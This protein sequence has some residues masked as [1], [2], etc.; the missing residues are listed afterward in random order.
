MC[1]R[2]LA[3]PQVAIEF[4]GYA[5]RS[6]GRSPEFIVKSG[7]EA[8]RAPAHQT[9]KPTSVNY[10]LGKATPVPLQFCTFHFSIFSLHLFIRTLV[11]NLISSV[12]RRLARRSCF[13]TPV[14][15]EPLIGITPDVTL[16]GGGHRLREPQNVF[17]L[18]AGPL[19][20]QGFSHLKNQ[21]LPLVIPWRKGRKYDR[22]RPQ[23]QLSDDERGRC[24]S[25]KEIHK[26]CF[27]FE[28]VQIHE[29]SQSLAASQYLEHLA[30]GEPL[31]DRSIPA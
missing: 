26:H 4:L 28:R 25:P 7:P 17:S 30:G 20:R 1:G 29:D 12:N 8:R 13:P 31:V 15:P 9:A 5:H 3:F 21:F 10:F 6:S 16:D 2:P 14:N 11:P 27:A 22:A 23:R 18:V 24:F 19:E